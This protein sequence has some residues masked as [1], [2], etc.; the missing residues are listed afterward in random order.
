ML[1]TKPALTLLQSYLIHRRR[2]RFLLLAR[3]I[4]NTVT[5]R[6][7]REIFMWVYD[8]CHRQQLSTH[9]RSENAHRTRTSLL[10]CKTYSPQNVP[11]FRRVLL[12]ALFTEPDGF[13][14]LRLSS[15]STGANFRNT[16][17]SSVLRLASPI[18]SANNISPLLVTTVI[19]VPVRHRCCHSPYRSCA[20]LRQ[21]RY[22]G[23]TI[24]EEYVARV[25]KTRGTY[26][27]C[28]RDH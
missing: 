10:L 4:L 2:V 19:R 5:P 28:P 9:R 7:T 3:L 16:A 25:S 12:N 20:L 17:V 8:P 21:S 1:F 15:S 18:S 27:T 13:K 11:K 24:R 6:V 22:F 23:I 14:M 26:T